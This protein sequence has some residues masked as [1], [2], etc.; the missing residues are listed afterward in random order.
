[1]K[2]SPLGLFTKPVDVFQHVHSHTKFSWLPTE[3]PIWPAETAETRR[4]RWNM[5]YAV[6][7]MAVEPSS[8]IIL[9]YPTWLPQ[10]STTIL[11]I[12]A[13]LTATFVSNAL[14]GPVV[15]MR[16]SQEL[17]SGRNKDDLL[18]GRMAIKKPLL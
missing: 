9:L 8:L 2:A 18:L 13:S 10:T 7:S 3:F 1:M 11:I 4:N 16:L 12:E 5:Q 17:C 6:D 14:N 15:S